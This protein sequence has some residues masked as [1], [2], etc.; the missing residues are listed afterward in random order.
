[1]KRSDHPPLLSDLLRRRAVESGKRPAYIFLRDGEVAAEELTWA[2]LDRRAQALA[3]SLADCGE[4]GTHARIFVN[5][6]VY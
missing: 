1:M 6:S 3:A 2:E 5:L 4:E